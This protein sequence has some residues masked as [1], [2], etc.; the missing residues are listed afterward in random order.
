MVGVKLTTTNIYT[1]LQPVKISPSDTT[2]FVE[3]QV[4][5]L[6][7]ASPKS[8]IRYT[9]D[10]S[11]PTPDSL[12]Y[13]APITLT[14]TTTVKARSLRPGTTVLPTTMS[15]TMASIVTEALYDAAP[16]AKAVE[17]P[18]TAPGLKYDYYEGRWQDLLSGL[19]RLQPLKSGQVERLF[20]TSAKG[21]SPTYAFKYSGYF[22]APTD[23]IYNFTA[24]PEYY[25]PNIMAGYELRVSLDGKEW[26]P[27]T[28]RHALGVW[29]VGLAK[30]KHEF[31]VL[32]A[33]LRADGVQKMNK[34]NLKPAVWEGTAPDVQLS[35]PGLPKGPIASQLLSSAK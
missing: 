2:A 20:D 15:G 22:E 25:E 29:S 30:G 8:E 11:E 1:P 23:G 19:D 28:S 21:A 33:D 17:A 34:L 7:S 14:A 27:T 26:Y 32:F 6:A 31:S 13:S 24:P 12:L 9:L 10:G 4:V 5:T 18:A 16:L 35:G 3:K